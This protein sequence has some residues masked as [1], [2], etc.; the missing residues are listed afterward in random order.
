MEADWPGVDRAFSALDRIAPD[1]PFYDA[2]WGAALLAKGDLDG[3]I[4][5]LT[6]AHLKGPHFADPLDLWGETLMKKGDFTIAIAKFAEGDKY[7]PKWG[8]N[9]LRWGEALMLSGRYA[10][11][12]AQYVAASRMDLSSP[13]ARL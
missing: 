9:H 3:A 4:A 6:L 7:A 10:E 8:R 2:D 11:A 1:I 12:R 5:K 13:T